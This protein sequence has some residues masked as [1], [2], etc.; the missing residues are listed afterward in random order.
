M[1]AIIDAFI[2][3]RDFFETGGWVLWVIFVTTVL[4]WTLI[5]ERIW[6]YRSALPGEVK[7]IFEIWHNRTDHSSW[8]ARGFVSSWS[9]RYRWTPIAGS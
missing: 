6:F 1:T 7:E 4:M 3:V 9:P 5:I 8:Y 2:S